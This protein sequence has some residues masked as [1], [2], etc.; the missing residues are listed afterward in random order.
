MNISQHRCTGA[1]S[2]IGST[3]VPETKGTACKTQLKNQT[4]AQAWPIQ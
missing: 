2:R 3:V 4:G 1:M